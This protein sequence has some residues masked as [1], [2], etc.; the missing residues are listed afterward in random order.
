MSLLKYSLWFMPR[1]TVYQQLSQ[2]ISQLGEQYSSPVFPP[3]VT[4]IDSI[5]AQEEEIISKA[6]EL[7]LLMRPHIIKLTNID[8]TD[9]YYRALF[10]RIE[11]SADIL[12]AY[13][14]ARKFFPSDQKSNYMPHL[15]L[16]Y[17]NFAV[18]TKQAM[19]KEVGSGFT[20]EFKADALHLYLTEGAVNDWREIRVF[21][22]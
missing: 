4:L 5:E 6:Q 15:S 18:E 8:F 22:L 9:Y 2:C 10:L 1:D 7:A 21:T 3:H 17:G 19:I 12:A 11:P 16:L 20:G 14:Q 13:Q